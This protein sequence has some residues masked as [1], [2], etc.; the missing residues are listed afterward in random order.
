[1]PNQLSHWSRLI[2]KILDILHIHELE[3]LERMKVGG[4]VYFMKKIKFGVF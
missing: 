3:G 2:W 1:M 4:Y